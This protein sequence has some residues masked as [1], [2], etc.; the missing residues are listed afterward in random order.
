VIVKKALDGLAFFL[1]LVEL[2]KRTN[3]AEFSFN[4]QGLVPRPKV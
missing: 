1:R 4:R 3:A 2:T